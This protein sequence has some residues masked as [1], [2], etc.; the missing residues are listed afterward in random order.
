MLL[1]PVAMLHRA[2]FVI[3]LGPRKAEQKK[4]KKRLRSE[5]FPQPMTIIA[6]GESGSTRNATQEQLEAIG[7]TRRGLFYLWGSKHQ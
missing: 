3:D 6:Q 5:S 4:K 2:F 1:F 7:G